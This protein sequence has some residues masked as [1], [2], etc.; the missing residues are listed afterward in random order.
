MAA[1]T[2]TPQGKPAENGDHLDPFQPPAAGHAVGRTGDDALPRRDAQDADVEKAA[3]ASAQQEQKY[4]NR[5]RRPVHL[6]VS[7]QKEIRLQ[8]QRPMQLHH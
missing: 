6:D 8:L 4:V 7:F 3:H 2:P 1:G 5:K